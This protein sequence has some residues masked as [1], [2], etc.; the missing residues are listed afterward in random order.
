MN[1]ERKY[2]TS[3][4]KRE[5]VKQYYAKNGGYYNMCKEAIKK[6][7]KNVKRE[8]GKYPNYH[9]KNFKYGIKCCVLM[10]IRDLFKESL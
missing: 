10:S 4:K 5:A 8:T 3:E 7:H 6:Y 2:K 9:K 1:S